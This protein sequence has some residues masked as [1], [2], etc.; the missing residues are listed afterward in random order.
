MFY[1]F[2]RIAVLLF[3]FL[4]LCPVFFLSFCL[5]EALPT[6]MI[7]WPLSACLLQSVPEPPYSL[8]RLPPPHTPSPSLG[9]GPRTGSPSPPDVSGGA[10][11]SS[12][13]TG[14]PPCSRLVLRLLRRQSLSSATSTLSLSLLPLFLFYC[15]SSSVS[16]ARITLARDGEVFDCIIRCRSV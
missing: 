11:S 5:S 10:W 14:P 13:T 6:C 8:Q 2:S 7:M 1:R 4:S 9:T 16:H 3:C 15:L 12:D